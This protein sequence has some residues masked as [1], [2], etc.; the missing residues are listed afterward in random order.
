MTD[1]AKPIKPTTWQK[2]LQK[3]V[4]GAVV[5]NLGVFGLLI[6]FG[7]IQ[8]SSSTP[9]EM[10]YGINTITA[11]VLFIPLCLTLIGVGMLFIW[12]V[13]QEPIR[14]LRAWLKRH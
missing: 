8:F 9:E 6:K 7:I 2:D 1:V 11:K 12:V 3:L 4:L 5:F 13:L 14:E 10:L